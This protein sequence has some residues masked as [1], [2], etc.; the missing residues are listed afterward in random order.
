VSHTAMDSE[1]LFWFVVALT[2]LLGMLIGVVFM[3]PPETLGSPQPQAAGLAGAPARSAHSG[4]RPRH[5]GGMRPDL[6]AAGRRQ[7]S[8]GPPWEPAP[9][10]S[11]LADRDTVPWPLVPGLIPGKASAHWELPPGPAHR[12]APRHSAHRVAQS[13]GQGRSPVGVTGRHRA[14]VH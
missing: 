10:P 13:I 6:M 5:A 7:V 1:V 11:G 4:Y 2:V 9:W 12:H 3:T 14:G 8:A